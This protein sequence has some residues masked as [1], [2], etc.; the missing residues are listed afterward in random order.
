MTE[1]NAKG[2]ATSKK[3][4]DERDKKFAATKKERRERIAI[5]GKPRGDRTEDQI[6]KDYLAKSKREERESATE[7]HSYPMRNETFE[8]YKQR[9]AKESRPEKPGYQR[10]GRHMFDPTP[11]DYLKKLIGSEGIKGAAWMPRLRGT[12][13]KSATVEEYLEAAPGLMGKLYPPPRPYQPPDRGMYEEF[14]TEE[15]ATK[16]EWFEEYGP[17]WQRKHAHKFPAGDYRSQMR[18]PDSARQRGAQEGGRAITR[19]MRRNTGSMR[20]GTLFGLGVDVLPTGGWRTNAEVAKYNHDRAFRMEVEMR[21]D[22]SRSTALWTTPHD[23]MMQNR[24][25]RRTEW[26]RRE[27][28]KPA[29]ESAVKKTPRQAAMDTEV[30]RAG[31]AQHQQMRDRQ[32]WRRRK[33]EEMWERAG[34]FTDTQGAK[35]GGQIGGSG[36]EGWKHPDNRA[37]SG[38]R[39]FGATDAQIQEAYDRVEEGIG[40]KRRPPVSKKPYQGG[41]QPPGSK[42]GVQPTISPEKKKGKG[43]G[44]MTV[45]EETRL[46]AEDLADSRRSF[47]PENLAAL[48]LDKGQP[49]VGTVLKLGEQGPKGQRGKLG[50]TG[51]KKQQQKA[52]KQQKRKQKQ[53]NKAAKR[54][55]RRRILNNRKKKKKKKNRSEG[56]IPNFYGGVIG[57][58]IAREAKA[59]IS[60]SQMSLEQSDRLINRDNPEGFAITNPSPTRGE[61]LGVEQGIDRAISMGMDPRK[62]GAARGYI[63]NFAKPNPKRK[64]LKKIFIKGAGK[65]GGDA[66]AKARV[67]RR[68]DTALQA[69]EKAKLAGDAVAEKKLQTR[70]A[71]IRER[72]D[73]LHAKTDPKSRMAKG[74]P[75]VAPPNYGGQRLVPG[76]QNIHG[77]T[78]QQY[79]PWNARPSCN[80]SPFSGYKTSTLRGTTRQP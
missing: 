24:E 63:P 71:G 57:E 6:M 72:L 70:I 18:S 20:R 17:E 23:K 60:V 50:K 55:R 54:E 33:S 31:L 59:G 44:G 25:G 9:H 2:V 34:G 69:L 32:L 14:I 66:V 28:L 1:K 10:Y 49:G 4:A 41:P 40:G 12:K 35:A 30:G 26:L 36:G 65:P 27:M 80:G 67:R 39:Y 61:P 16:A 7:I 64:P 29:G 13:G 5:D 74:P 22:K 48:G 53:L 11:M 77:A 21:K 51:G 73:A 52:Q 45:E 78:P 15:N 8:E 76:I 56:F 46:I 62:H 37:H 79:V 19:S 58:A 43:M 3:E 75:G 42:D 68:M 47:S 38:G